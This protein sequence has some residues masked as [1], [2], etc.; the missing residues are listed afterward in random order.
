LTIASE[1][2]PLFVVR[3]RPARIAYWGKLTGRYSIR[4]R[5]TIARV[6]SRTLASARTHMRS[7]RFAS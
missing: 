6:R 5:P 3:K 1:C 4:I 7:S 2:L